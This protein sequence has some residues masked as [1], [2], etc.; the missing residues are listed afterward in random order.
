MGVG[1]SGAGG[2][3]RL[4]SQMGY[5]VSGCD[6]EEITSY[7]QTYLKGHDKRH[8][9]EIDL[10]IASPALYY[11]KEKN[12]EIELAKSKNILV[13]WQEFLGKE[14][15]KNKKVI[16]IAGTHGKSTTTAMVGKMLIDA[17]L[18]PIVVLGANVPEWSG[19]SRFGKGEYA[20]VEADEFND[21]F[22]NYDPY[23]EVINNVEFDHPDFFQD[24]NEM[25]NSFNKF[26]DK[27]DPHGV[28]IINWN[29][30]GIQRMLL[31]HNEPS[32]YEQFKT[33][34][35]FNL[36][37]FGQH[38]QENAMMVYRLGRHLGIPEDEIIKSIESF[39]G[40]GRRMELIADKNGIK[41]F[42]DYA[43]HPT[44]IKTTLEGLR[45]EFPNSKIL[46]I[47][48]PHGYKR[49]KALLQEYIGVFDSLDEVIIGPIFKA[50]DEIDPSLTPQMIAEVSEHVNA[51]GYNS[52]EEIIKNLKLQ[53]KNYDVV[54]V[55]GAGKSYLWAKEI[56]NLIKN[57]GEVSFKK[58]TTFRIGGNIKKYFEVKTRREIDSA[59]KYAK[60]NNLS[61]FIIGD[62]S[63][64]LVSDKNYD[65]MVIKYIGKSY[66]WNVLPSIVSFQA[67]MSW[68]EA[69]LFTTKR[70]LQGI[71]C[72]SGIPGTVGA[73]PIQNIGAYGQE[74]KDTFISLKAYD[75]EKRK[76]VNFNKEDC[77]FSY[78]ESIFKDKEYWQKYLITEVTFQLVKNGKPEVKYESLKNYLVKLKITSPTLS[79]VRNAVIEI[80]KGKFE[81]PKEVGNAGSFFKNPIVS[82]EQKEQLKK[83]YPDI[84]TFPFEKSFKIA[85]GWLIE[86][87]D[88]KGKKYKSAAVSP[89][90]ALILINPEGNAKAEDVYELSEKIIAD[91]YNKFDIKL[92]REVQ[93]INF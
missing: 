71:E 11:S 90:H 33:H 40:I 79:D 21:N 82:K 9:E 51:F 47:V 39:I 7:G 35:K 16:A 31:K 20:V 69:V 53:I 59:I 72:L 25:V 38:N 41:V 58:L 5:E 74:L 81:N 44:A 17:G 77:R 8:L 80:R 42:D 12:E 18:D 22:L 68:D 86:K 1:G 52:F 78:R 61:I 65:G 87:A 32:N 92:E 26:I 6:K 75:L 13:T 73:A 88:W 93:L 48:E 60:S 84:K 56:A 43:H 3:A 57:G 62:G 63:D 46:A 64:L 83:D 91:I 34:K 24:E 10:V 14:L 30:K 15:L 70:N 37:I 36:K 23:I 27:M 55:M 67:G 54:V 50:R 85:A 19:T 49:T 89:K 29:D 2:V 45:S 28:L 4:A 76:F 66:K